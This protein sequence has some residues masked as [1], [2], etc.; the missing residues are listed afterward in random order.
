MLDSIFQ[1]F[2]DRSPVTIMAAGTLKRV[3]S[4][5]RLDALFED[6]RQGQ[7]C[8]KLL[9]SS[10]FDLMAGVVTGTRRSIHHAY[11]TA[12]EPLGVSVVAVYDKLKGIET[13][14]SQALARNVATELAPMIQQL[15][16]ELPALF[17]G[18]QTRILDG[19]CIAATEH[20]IKEL[21]SVASGALPGKSL[22]VLDA[23]HRLIC[24]VFPCEDGHAQERALLEQVIPTITQDQLWIDDRNF[25]TFD[26]LWAIQRADAFFITR[27]HGGMAFEPIGERRKLGPTQTGCVF[28]QSIVVRG[29]QGRTL[30]LRRIEVQLNEATRDGETTIYLLSNLP[31]DG[32]RVVSGQQIAEGYRSR[33][34]IETAFQELAVHLNSEIH[35]LGYPKAA[36]FGFC[37]AVVL[38]NAV[39]L[40]QA[41]LRGVHGAEKVQKEVSSYYIAAE[42][43]TT[44]R[45]MM[46]A[47]PEA[48][49]RTFTELST[50]EFVADLQMLASKINLAHYKKHP[51]GPK[52]PK[53]KATYD[54]AHPHVAT[55]RLLKQ[56]PTR[57]R[58]N[59]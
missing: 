59:R 38:Y 45:G 9:F 56:R 36:L 25:C 6:S 23:Q 10:T 44:S 3:F 37:V 29:D 41:A 50:D 46:I 54:P 2:V 4:P 53:P 55:S 21:R 26:F 1:P 34:T 13:T 42:I 51:R 49:W 48:S 28:E 19:N 18:Y 31:A 35:T 7:Y 47:I 20:R 14:T 17:P 52:K 5:Q 27:Q 58:K 32:Q 24:D 22:V 11:Q 15:G 33:W 30:T 39:S 40:L 57:K 16:G 8:H 12:Q 43:Q